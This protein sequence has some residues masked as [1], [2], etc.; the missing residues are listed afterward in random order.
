MI[1]I[2]VLASILY[3]TVAMV[4]MFVPIGEV[5]PPENNM[6]EIL[7]QVGA[8]HTAFVMPVKNQ[9]MDIREHVPF[10]KMFLIDS[11]SD[12][13]S[14]S[15]GDRAF[16]LGTPTWNEFKLKT[17]FNALFR[18][19]A[20]AIHVEY[21]SGRPSGKGYYNL[22]LPGD[23][24]V[25]LVNYIRSFIK[26]DEKGRPQKIVGYSYYGTDE[27]YEANNNFHLFHT[28]NVWTSNGLKRSGVKTAIWSP[29]PIGI[30][31]QL[32]Q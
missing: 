28:C 21:F 30:Q 23:K 1:F 3:V 2:P 8:I 32:K 29:F 31:Y 16:F 13:I 6:A 25:Q 15:W 7:I 5:Y 12:Y 27:F 20:S 24:Y 9:Y 4:C 19:Q 22:Y 10:S 11:N 17:A 26:Q 18:S 14:I